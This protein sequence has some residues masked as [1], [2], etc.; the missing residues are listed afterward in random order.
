MTPTWYIVQSD[1]T[2]IAE[3]RFREDQID[4]LPQAILIDE[5]RYSLDSSGGF[6][7]S[8]PATDSPNASQPQGP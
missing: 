1:Y 7:R 2:P 3:I 4:K 5:V 8:E 6:Y